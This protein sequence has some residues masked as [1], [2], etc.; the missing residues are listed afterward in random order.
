MHVAHGD[1]GDEIAVEQRRAGER[2]AVAADHAG[3]AR[4]RQARCQCRDLVRLLALVAGKRAGEGI[5]QQSLAVLLD[6]VWKLL[7]SQRRGKLRQ[8]L[9]CFFRHYQL[10]CVMHKLRAAKPI[11]MVELSKWVD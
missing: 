1:G 7:V 11:A 6:P 9:C 2:E 4:L 10:P 5:E 8:R 3:F